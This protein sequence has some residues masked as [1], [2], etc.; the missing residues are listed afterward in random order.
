L[1]AQ[2]KAAVAPRRRALRTRKRARAAYLPSAG[3]GGGGAAP[4]RFAHAETGAAQLRRRSNDIEIEKNDFGTEK[5]YR[6][7]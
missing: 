7:A 5:K 2:A 3:K 6:F 4:P 1:L